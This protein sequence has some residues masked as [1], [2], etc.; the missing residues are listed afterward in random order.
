MSGTI[1]VVSELPRF[2]HLTD[3]IKNTVSKILLS[4]SRP[5]ASVNVFLLTD[6][7]IMELNKIARQ[8]NR[9]T[10]ILSFPSPANFP[11]PDRTDFLG[12][13]Y[14]A[15]DF[16]TKEQDDLKFLL[17]HGLLHLLGYIHD[18]E[19]EASIMEEVEKRLLQKLK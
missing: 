9:I 5:S 15:P 12:D 11:S 2:S 16:Y 19:A 4:L 8:H 7:S 6:A 18:S 3:E 13:L 1:E 14:L 17:I 10:N